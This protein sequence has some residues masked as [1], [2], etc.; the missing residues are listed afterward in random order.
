MNDFTVSDE[1]TGQVPLLIGLMGGPGAGKT[2]SALTLAAGMALPGLGRPVVI[3]TEGG[4][5]LRYKRDAGFDF[6]R[7]DFKPPFRPERFAGAIKAALATNPCAII[8]DSMSDEHEGTGGVL[9]WHEE[10]LTRMAGQDYAKRER[11]T[12]AAWIKVKA[13]R[14]AM[15]NELQLVKTPMIFCFRAREKTK[16]MKDDRGKTA[17]TNIGWQ[18]IA[19]AEIVHAMD[20]T[21]LL[22]LRS[23]GVPQWRSEK[24]TED[25]VIKLPLQFRSL[26]ADGEALSREHGRALAAWARGDTPSQQPAGPSPEAVDAAVAQCEVAA[27]FSTLS[28]L[29]T[30]WRSLSREIKAAI[31]ASRLA[32]WKARVEANAKD[33]TP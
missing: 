4:R 3:D 25:F 16:P 10:E 30:V 6:L 13:Q 22:P 18:P 8:V 5:S 33:D 32:E 11:C 24:A 28:A 20:I 7:I 21:C 12:Q 31:G 29:E 17:P 15:L 19:P 26:F 9:E 2:F 1:A 27:G 14:R 23:D